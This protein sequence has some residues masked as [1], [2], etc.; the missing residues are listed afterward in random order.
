MDKDQYLQRLKEIAEVKR[1]KE[2]TTS[3]FRMPDEPESIFRNGEE[4]VISK[5]ENPTQA[6]Q[7]TRLKPIIKP[8]EDC[9][10]VV[11]NR[12]VSHKIYSFPHAH[13]RTNCENCRRTKNP[14]TG[15][16]D[17]DFKNSQSVFISF[18]SNRNK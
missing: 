10:L 17:V 3:A 4:I 15:K 7:I 8:C 6:Y 9:G 12:I 1:V 5:K 13:W 2:P 18:F 16:F 11:E 14:E